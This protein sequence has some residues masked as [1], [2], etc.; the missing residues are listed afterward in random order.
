MTLFRHKI[1]WIL[2]F[3]LLTG[4]HVRTAMNPYRYAAPSNECSWNPCEEDPIPNCLLMESA[5][6]K[7]CS[8]ID[9]EESLDLVSLLDIALKRSPLTRRTWA[10]AHLASARWGSSQ[11]K[12]FPELDFGAFWEALRNPSFFG[13]NFVFMDEFREYGPYLT[14]S[15]LVLDFGT[16]RSV[17]QAFYQMLLESN[18]THNREI[19]TVIHTVTTDY[20]DLVTQ[21]EKVVAG[22]AN[23]HDA[24]TTLAA[25]QAKH[26]YGIS[27]ITDVYTA[28]TFVAKQMMTLLADQRG[29][30]DSQATLLADAGLPANTCV[31]IDN[32][33]EQIDEDEL[34]QSIDNYICLAYES[35]PDLRAA[36]AD[37]LANESLVQ[38]AINNQLPKVTF[39]GQVGE[40]RF[41]DSPRDFYSYSALFTF[42]YPLFKGWRYTNEI[43]EAQ[44]L[45]EVSKTKLRETEVNMV[46]DVVQGY[47][48]FN[49]STQI[50][51][52]NKEYV[53]LAQKSYTANLSEYKAGTIDITTL[54]NAQTNL[55]DARYSL[56]ES[57]KNWYDA[58]TNLMY[59]TGVVTKPCCPGGL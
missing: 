54:V 58:L 4:C 25:T 51:K 8:D 52:V 7:E 55:A 56:A 46:K 48:D 45:L 35:R 12:F 18:W 57:R 11:S 23:L 31:D 49:Y 38:A 29:E 26:K 36:Y 42:T 41:N 17:S 10:R 44:S 28:E 43:R 3:L 32:I 13:T 6:C 5:D 9:I 21:R 19:Q 27:D 14:L 16:T 50:V 1:L 20:Y 53:D 24:N 59:A 2:A 33:A 40:N 15:Y 30:V 37:V 22:E 47:Q 34:L 39:N